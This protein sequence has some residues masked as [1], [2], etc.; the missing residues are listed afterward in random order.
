MSRFGSYKVNDIHIIVIYV[1]G[2]SIVDSYFFQT[3]ELPETYLAS[4][5]NFPTGGHVDVL[6][7]YYVPEKHLKY[8]Q[9]HCNHVIDMLIKFGQ[10]H[11]GLP[12]NTD[13]NV[14]SFSASAWSRQ[15]NWVKITTLITLFLTRL[16]KRQ[17][18]H[19]TESTRKHAI[20]Y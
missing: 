12:I 8:L 11:V 1:V 7:D 4:V 5:V 16:F 15:Q 13:Q 9:S 10:Y 3:I 18:H 20:L 14:V 2:L 6:S 17:T 19:S